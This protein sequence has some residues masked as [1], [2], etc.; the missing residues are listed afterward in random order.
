VFVEGGLRALPGF[1]MIE[2]DATKEFFFVHLGFDEID[3][4]RNV[5]NRTGWN[6]ERF[7]CRICH[8]SPCSL[9]EIFSGVRVE[10]LS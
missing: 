7:L 3:S 2:A 5:S 8:S 4:E 1:A 10:D 9:G 6:Y